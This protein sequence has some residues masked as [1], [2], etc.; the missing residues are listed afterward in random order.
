MR[1]AAPIN[2]WSFIEI[3]LGILGASAPALKVLFHR[4]KTSKSKSKMVNLG[5]G[6]SKPPAERLE[7]VKD[8]ECHQRGRPRL[9]AC[10]VS[11]GLT[12]SDSE[13]QGGGAGDDEQ[14]CNRGGGSSELTLV[15]LMPHREEKL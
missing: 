8:S 12:D 14:L 15:E 9:R 11:S 7:E 3:N 13:R 1:D 2:L 10:D 4:Q 5:L 6:I